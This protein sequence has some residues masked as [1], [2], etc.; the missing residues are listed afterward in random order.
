MAFLSEEDVVLSNTAAVRGYHYYRKF[1]K[2][3]ENEDIYCLHENSVFM[4]VLLSK[5]GDI[6]DHWRHELARVIKCLF[7]DRGDLM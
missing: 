3:V 6:V 2:P 5:N 7:F 4:T 1:W